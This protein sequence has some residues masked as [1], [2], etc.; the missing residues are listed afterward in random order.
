MHY[1]LLTLATVLAHSQAQ[2]VPMP[3]GLAPVPIGQGQGQGSNT[4]GEGQVGHMNGVNMPEEIQSSMAQFSMPFPAATPSPSSSMANNMHR[5]M[6]S[7]HYHYHAHHHYYM[8]PMP[9]SA[10]HY[11][12]MHMSASAS[13]SASMSYNLYA[14]STP[15]A[16]PSASASHIPYHG[17]NHGLHAPHPHEGFPAPKPEGVPK[18]PEF[19]SQNGAST[20]HGG[21]SG[22]NGNGYTQTHGEDSSSDGSPPM[23]FNGLM[24]EPEESQA[25][26][27]AMPES[28]PQEYSPESQPQ[29][30]EESTPEQYCP[31]QSQST[32]MPEESTPEAPQESSPEDPGVPSYGPNVPQSEGVNENIA[33]IPGTAPSEQGSKSIAPVD[34]MAPGTNVAPTQPQKSHGADLG[35]SFCM[36]DCYASPDEAK[37]EKPYSSPVFQ[38]ASGCYSCCFTSPDF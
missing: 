18:A 31:E 14:S 33:P 29:S 4:N 16:T 34:S 3:F 32:P 21:Y 26:Q 10:S 30:P 38:E 28:T 20:K 24:S 25:P 37:C 1:T 11:I 5:P 2:Y 27:E 35:N 17:V 8:T 36:G 7:A 22:G 9:S 23:N 13:A 6:Q 12:N 19:T 15:Y